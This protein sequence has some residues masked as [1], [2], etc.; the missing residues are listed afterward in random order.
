MVTPLGFIG[1]FRIYKLSW[2]S[3]IHRWQW[4]LVTQRPVFIWAK[5]LIPIL[6]TP[7][8]FQE[9]LHIWNNTGS[10]GWIVK[11]QRLLAALYVNINSHLYHFNCNSVTRC[12]SFNWSFW[13]M[14][15]I[16]NAC[17]IQLTGKCAVWTCPHHYTLKNLFLYSVCFVWLNSFPREGR[18]GGRGTWE[19][20]V[21]QW[22][23]LSLFP[24][25]HSWVS[26]PIPDYH[27]I[28]KVTGPLLSELAAPRG[29]NF[30]VVA[31]LG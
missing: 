2:F 24:T 20:G 11:P 5:F 7:K 31:T 12:I 3:Q 21:C 26:N 19:V 17:F 13:E 25:K 14:L 28:L 4:K 6:V 16:K 1:L 27:R 23:I 18:G 29:R 15:F 9:L 22:N 30:R 10:L 8:M